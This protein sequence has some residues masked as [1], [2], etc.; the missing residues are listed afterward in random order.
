MTGVA[1]T[2]IAKPTKLALPG[3][4]NGIGFD[5]LMFVPS[6][7]RVLAPAGRTGKLDLIDPKTQKIESVTGFS[8]QTA[9]FVTALP[10]QKKPRLPVS[11]CGVSQPGRQ[12]RM[13]PRKPFVLAE[14][15]SSNVSVSSSKPC[16]RNWLF[17]SE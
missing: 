6:L 5:D 10:L 4:A 1:E 12:A 3:G 9:V 14:G 11:A 7:H 13:W 2:P 17:G 15:S 16:T 8:T